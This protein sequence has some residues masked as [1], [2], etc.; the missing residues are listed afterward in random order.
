MTIG[1]RLAIGLRQD[2]VTLDIAGAPV[3][4]S[5]GGFST[6]FVALDPPQ[7]WAQVAR[8]SQADV[9]RLAPGTVITTGTHTVRM[10]FHPGVTTGVRVTWAD[11]A[12][13]PHQANV[14]GV[15]YT[16]EC[17]ETMLVCEEV[18]P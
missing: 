4:D 7:M 10:P 17:T 3:P 14:T 9:E 1:T 6:P 8:A 11:R 13:R 2:R 16:P 5:D 12:G 18:L 15:S